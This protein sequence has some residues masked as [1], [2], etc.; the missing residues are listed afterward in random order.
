[1]PVPQLTTTDCGVHWSPLTQESGKI[2]VSY[3]FYSLQFFR[4][5]TQKTPEKT[6]Y[7]FEQNVILLRYLKAYT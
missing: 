7:R 3:L 5:Y 2:V 4:N 1:M 6:I